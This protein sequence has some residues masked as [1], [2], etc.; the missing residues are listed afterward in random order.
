VPAAKPEIVVLAVEP[1]MTPGLIVQL[2]VGKPLNTTRPVA[3]AQDGCVMTP[4]ASAIGVAGCALTTTLDEAVDAH[5]AAL[6]TV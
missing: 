5:P 3:V 4:I 6:V 1:D 2:P